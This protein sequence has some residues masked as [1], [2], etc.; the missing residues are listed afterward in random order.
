MDKRY[1]F[2]QSGNTVIAVTTYAGKTVR[3]TATCADGDTFDLEKGQ[4][5]AMARCQYKVALKREKRAEKCVE[6]AE[7]QVSIAKRYRRK[8]KD[9]RKD[10]RA[11]VSAAHLA[12]KLIEQD[13][14][15]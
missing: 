12:L 8:M 6:A 15:D 14:A 2:Y 13:M 4:R 9:Y 10:A 5:L 3:A 11:G 7:E 1:K